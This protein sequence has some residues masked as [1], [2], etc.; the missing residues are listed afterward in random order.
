MVYGKIIDSE[1][2]MNN[3][4]KRYFRLKNSQIIQFKMFT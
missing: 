3:K 2:R 1:K 4:N